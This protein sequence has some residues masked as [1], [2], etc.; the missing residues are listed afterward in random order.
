MKA[1]GEFGGAGNRGSR[2]GGPQFLAFDRHGHLYT[3]EAS[4]GRIQRLDQTGQPLAAWGD[5]S[6]GPGGFEHG[7]RG[8]SLDW[9]VT[10]VALS[11]A[12]WR[13]ASPSRLG[14]L[15]GKLGWQDATT[16]LKLTYAHADTSLNGNGL[17][18]EKFLRRNYGSV[19]TKPDV[20][21]ARSHFANLAWSHALDEASL[22]SGHAYYRE[23][24]T[25]TGTRASA[26]AS[27]EMTVLAICMRASVPSCMRAPPDAATTMRGS[28]FCAA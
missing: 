4:A 12:G 5:N 27:S 15:F 8:S 13:E 10:G 18:E 28:P 17:Q 20:T 11:D 21:Q 2:F 14:Q 3:T 1:P 7:G 24:T 16:D 6:D 19:Y 9:Y 23:S 22:F 25:T 26:R